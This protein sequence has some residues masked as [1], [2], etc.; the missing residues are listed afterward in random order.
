MLVVSDSSPLNFMIRLDCVSVLPE[1]FG[2]VLIPPMVQEELGRSTT[3]PIVREFMAN[4]PAWLQVRAPLNIEHIPKLDPGEEAAIS[5]AREVRADA[6]L[7]DEKAGRAAAAQR[8]FATIGLLGI[9]DRADERRLID[10][11]KLCATLPADYRVD[12]ALVEATLERSRQRKH[13]ET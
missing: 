3:P 8:G 2:I 5:L 11:E 13:R 12:F 10:F 1:L 7:M 6:V 9:L 4:R